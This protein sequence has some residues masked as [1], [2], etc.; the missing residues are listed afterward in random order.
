M[1]WTWSIER[2][3]ET[4][5]GPAHGVL[6]GTHDVLA[7]THDVLAGDYQ[8]GDIF[9]DQSEPIDIRLARFCSHF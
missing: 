1:I 8:I 2:W 4:S 6:A 7:G 3:R 5:C 9:P